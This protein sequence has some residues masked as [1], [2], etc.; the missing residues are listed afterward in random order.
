MVLAKT[1]E[2]IV[3]EEVMVTL[4]DENGCLGVMVIDD[5][6]VPSFESRKFL[7]GNIRASINKAYGNPDPSQGW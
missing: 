7:A 6:T 3:T 4:W 5:Q 2:N 1:D